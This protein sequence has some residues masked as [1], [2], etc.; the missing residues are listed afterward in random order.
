MP[1]P[2]VD[3]TLPINQPSE[4]ETQATAPAPKPKRWAWIA[5]GFAAVL[6]MIAIG[7]FFGYR[8]GLNNRLRQ[9]ASQVALAAATQFQLGVNDFNNGRYQVASERF[10]YVIKLDPNFPGASDMLM[11]SMLAAAQVSSP[12]QE[13]TPTTVLT[14]TPDLRG[15]EELFNQS[16]DA[17]RNQDWNLTLDTL[18]ALRT[19]ELTYRTVDVDGMYYIALR[20]RGI[21]KIIQEGNLEGGIYDLALAEQFA[22]LDRDALGY[23]SWA[24]LYLTGASFWEVDWPRV[25]D[26]FSQIY[27]SMPNLRDGSGWTAV[28]RYRLALIGYGDQLSQKGDYCAAKDQYAAA[29]AMSADDSLAATATYAQ[30][31]CAPPTSTPEPTQIILPTD[32]Q[33]VVPTTA[34]TTAPPTTAPSATPVTPEAPTADGGGGGA[35]TGG[36]G[37]STGG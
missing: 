20:F 3:D 24:R 14:P 22:P 1:E 37:G 26:A 15:A 13:A 11:K 4:E 5:A 8:I 16:V 6:V 10:E 27:P 34:P 35:G 32:T 7:S 21:S 28:E 2:N 9:E 12:V 30:V 17:M 25:I 31:Q 33:Q 36:D 29:L 19:E 23:R 18:D